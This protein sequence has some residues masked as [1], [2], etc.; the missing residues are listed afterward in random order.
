MTKRLVESYFAILKIHF[1]VYTMILEMCPNGCT[2][3]TN[4]IYLWSP[5]R[6][7]KTRQNM[8]WNKRYTYKLLDELTEQ[9]QKDSMI[10][11]M[12]NKNHDCFSLIQI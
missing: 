1:E 11:L 8:V 2:S 12:T 7:D 5:K 6:Q 9:Q 4:N 3:C 10:R